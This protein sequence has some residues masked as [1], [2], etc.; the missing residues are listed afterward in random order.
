LRTPQLVSPSTRARIQA[1]VDEFG[2]VPDLVAASLATRRSK[3]I[4]IILPTI[5]QALF[6]DTIQG[7]VDRL[8][9]AG[10]QLIVG[11][12]GYCGTVEASLVATL[13]GHR[14]DGLVLVGGE[15]LEPT[16]RLLANAGVP[17]VEIWELPEQPIDCVVGFSN[18]D[19]MYAMTGCL[20]E[21]GRRRVAFVSSRRN[22]RSLARLEG[23]LACL[24]DRGVSEPLSA[25]ASSS[26]HR[27]DPV[28][29]F[30]G[31][32]EA[33]PDLDAVCCSDDL[34]AM[35]LLF[36]CQRRGW[37]VPE[38]FAI[39]GLCDLEMARH[40]YPALTTVRVPGYE[41]GREAGR[42]ILERLDEP[43]RAPVVLDLGFEIVRRESA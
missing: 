10:Y 37:P 12:S 2:Y 16:R 22:P 5:T 8:R 23:Y 14:P 18:R 31:L 28:Q 24:R 36:A 21:A 19:A 43:A 33:H 13:L 25:V 9:P 34:I 35:L 11:E 38:R 4:A 42:I 7:L 15:H 3:V 1:A 40:V 39:C 20:L 30:V 29:A 26:E 32:V 41:I 27:L 17:V 6:A